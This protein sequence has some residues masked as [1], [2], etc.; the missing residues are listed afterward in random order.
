MGGEGGERTC[1]AGTGAIVP[2]PEVGP[3]LVRTEGLDVR[4]LPISPRDDFGSS[5]YVRVAAHGWSSG[6]LGRRPGQ[7]HGDRPVPS[8]GHGAGV[9]YRDGRQRL[10]AAGWTGAVLGGHRYGAALHTEHRAVGLA[11]PSQAAAEERPAGALAA[12]LRLNDATVPGYGRDHNLAGVL[13]LT[14][15]VGSGAAGHGA[16]TGARPTARSTHRASSNG[17]IRRAS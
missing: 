12:L 7:L 4:P 13:R 5:T 3:A 10:P 17:R 9:G 11:L 16:A 2:L 1:L 8:P 6:A 15:E 14:A